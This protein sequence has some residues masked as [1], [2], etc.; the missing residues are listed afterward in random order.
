MDLAAGI[1]SEH[2]LEEHITV[3]KQDVMY[4]TDNFVKQHR[5]HMIYTTATANRL[6]FWKIYLLACASTRVQA[7]VLP[8]CELPKLKK[9]GGDQVLNFMTKECMRTPHI[10]LFSKCCIAQ[11]AGNNGDGEVRNLSIMYMKDIRQNNEQLSHIQTSALHAS[12]HMVLQKFTLANNK[13]SVRNKINS[14]PEEVT[15][16]TCFIVDEEG[17]KEV[18]HISVKPIRIQTWR[19]KLKEDQHEGY[20]LTYLRHKIKLQLVKNNTYL[21]KWPKDVQMS[22]DP[23]TSERERNV[24]NNDDVSFVADMYEDDDHNS[25]PLIETR[26][27][28]WN[29]AVRQGA[30]GVADETESESQGETEAEETGAGHTDTGSP[31]SACLTQ[32]SIAAGHPSPIASANDESSNDE[33]SP[34][35]RQRVN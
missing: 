35:K 6:F 21:D 7:V 3:K 10:C 30:G 23:D 5:V 24:Y 33:S 25:L 26:H 12:I 16:A 34:P 32:N 18:G 20:A 11:A 17:E 9:D 19:K 4:I 28:T 15:G 31:G 13:Q 14:L 29:N 8:K 2:Q 22:A 27:N 1:V